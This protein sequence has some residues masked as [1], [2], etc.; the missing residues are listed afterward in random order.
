MSR[1]NKYWRDECCQAHGNHENDNGVAA[2]R[3][4]PQSSKQKDI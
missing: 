1:M 3:R 2:Q 4:P